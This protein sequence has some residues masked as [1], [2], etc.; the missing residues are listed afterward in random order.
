M[1]QGIILYMG[2]KHLAPSSRSEQQQQHKQSSASSMTRVSQTSR[3]LCVI[4]AGAAPHCMQAPANMNPNPKQGGS[5]TPRAWSCREGSPR[6][7]CFE[8]YV[9]QRQLLL[10]HCQ[11]LRTAA[12]L[13]LLLL[14]LP[15]PAIAALLLL[16]AAAAAPLP[17]ASGPP[18][19]PSASPR[20]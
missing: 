12:F 9:V 2:C 19:S 10:Q 4:P 16:T 11:P 3:A 1:V 7:W 13:C 14:L 18:P 6:C 8:A 5:R 15:A 17:P 20:Q